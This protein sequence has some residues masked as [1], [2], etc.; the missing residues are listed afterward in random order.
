MSLGKQCEVCGGT[1]KLKQ[2][3]SCLSVSYC[4]K[5]HQVADWRRHK[6]A[7]KITSE[8]R[9]NSLS[10]DMTKLTVGERAPASG[11]VGAS[12]CGNMV[13]QETTGENSGK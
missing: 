10:A 7:C 5:E 3:A 12:K 2:C 4:S 8:E 9:A 6:A 11:K 13:L 1:N